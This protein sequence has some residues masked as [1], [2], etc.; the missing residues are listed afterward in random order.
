MS[1]NKGMKKHLIH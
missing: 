1:M